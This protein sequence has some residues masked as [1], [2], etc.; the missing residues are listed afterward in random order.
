MWGKVVHAKLFYCLNK[1]DATGFELG[2]IINWA[3]LVLW[4]KYMCFLSESVVQDD[5]NNY[6]SQYYSEPSSGKWIIVLLYYGVEIYVC[7]MHQIHA[8]KWMVD[9][10]IFV[11]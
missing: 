11:V 1:K 7:Y 10:C 9:R 3:L 5:M 6:I 2:N 8:F 4:W